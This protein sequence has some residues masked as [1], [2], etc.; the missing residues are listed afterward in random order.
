[1]VLPFLALYMNK[2]LGYSLEEAGMA[3]T[4][5][6]AGAFFSAPFAGRISDRF[7]AHRIMVVS[8]FLSG[9][10][11]L[12]L[13]LAP[14][15]PFILVV[16]LIWSVISEAFRPA[17]LVMITELVSP[18]QRKMAFS[19][20][21][22]AINLGMSI[23]PALGG[24]LII[25]SYHLLFVVDS[26]TSILAGI[27]LLLAPWHPSVETLP[28]QEPT[29]QET[30][31]P[32][33]LAVFSDR[34]LLFFLFA[35]IPVVIVFFQHNSSMPLY[36]VNDLHLSTSTYGLLFTINTGLIILLEVPLNI[37]MS[38]WSHGRSLALGAFLSGLGFGLMSV[39]S[40]VLAV[41]A[42]VVVWTFGEM[43][44]FPSAANYMADLAPPSGRGTYMGMFQMTF[45]LSFALSGWLGATMLE[46][47]GGPALWVATFLA[48]CLSALMLWKVKH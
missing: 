44:L 18:A 21:R 42:T 34:N 25:M 33:P 3:V 16:T 20:N 32:R 36:L 1:M 45:S 17:S 24:V 4:V 19:V 23:G 9:V 13:M 6:G 35:L 2:T 22:L 47:F 37:R 26:V 31:R 5:Y 12:V 7:G 39:A 14:S 46:Q 30:N 15:Y 11:L 28:L 40:D 29:T 48:A 10:M 43:I 38:R 41:S 27:V 8:L